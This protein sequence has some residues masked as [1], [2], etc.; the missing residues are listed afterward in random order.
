[1]PLEGQLKARLDR[2]LGVVEDHGVRGTRLLED[3]QRLASR[4]RRFIQQG[5]IPPDSDPTPIELACYALQLPLKGLRMTP[6]GR[7]GRTNL[8]DR[9]EQAAE[10][11][12]GLAG[13]G[14]PRDDA[15]VEQ[16]TQ[17]LVQ[18]HQRNPDTDAA[19]LLADALSLEDFGVIGL[20]AQAIAIARQ[21]GG[22][23]TVA[24]GCEKREQYGYW[25]ARMKD[26]F[27]FEHIRTVAKKRLDHARKTA[28]LLL[29]ELRED[30][31]L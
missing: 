30:G 7:L 24:D 21:G 20:I 14:A 8:R 16:A 17:L 18:V 13:D 27:H 9:A 31:A 4:I 29:G 6:T 15:L 11:L 5:V 25:E 23:A 3:A 2:A 22:I 1:M 28:A 19:R 26:G 10:M 12:V